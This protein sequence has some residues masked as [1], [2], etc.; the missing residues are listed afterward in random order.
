MG[1]FL[2]HGPLRRRARLPLRDPRRPR[3][4]GAGGRATHGRRRQ[5]SR[6]RARLF[7]PR[8]QLRRV[9]VPIELKPVHQDLDRSGGRALT[10]VQQAWDYANHSPAAASSSSPTIKRPVSTAPPA[11]PT[12]VRPSS[13]T[14]SPSPKASSAFIISPRPRI[15]SSAP[16]PTFARPWKPPRLLRQG[17]ERLPISFMSNIGTC[18]RSSSLPAQEEPLQPPCPRSARLCPDHPRPRSS[19]SLSLRI[20]ALLP[21]EDTRAKRSPTATCTNL[22]PSWE[23]LKAVF[24]WIGCR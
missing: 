10:P 7:P 15:G 8:R 14:S 24:R 12:S 16:P 3:R 18:A 21:E 9:L 19:S 1:D 22:R 13:L 17:R 20:A 6:R 23:N 5:V 11:P 4:L 2:S